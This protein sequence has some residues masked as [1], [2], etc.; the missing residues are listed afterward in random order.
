MAVAP[1]PQKTALLLAQRIV[2]DIHRRGL[3]PGEKLPPEQAKWGLVV[4]LRTAG[5]LGLEIPGSVLV[6]ADEVIQ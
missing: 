2:R 5:A 1:R 6:R 4:N 3:A